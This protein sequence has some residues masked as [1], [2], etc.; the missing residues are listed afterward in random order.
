MDPVRRVAVAGGRRLGREGI[1]ALLA[2]VPTIELVA[3]CADRLTTEAAIERDGA[4]VVVTHV[5]LEGPGGGADL[6]VR[7]RDTH[8]GIGVVLLLGD[9][10]GDAEEVVEVLE[11]GTAQRALLLMDHPRVARDLVAAIEEVAEGGSVVHPGVV[12]RMLEAQRKPRCP[13]A[14]LTPRERQVL[15]VIATGAS[16]RVVAELLRL[17]DRALEKH[18]NQLYT[19]LGLPNDG[20]VHRRVAAT[21]VVH[22]RLGVA[23]PIAV[24]G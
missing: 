11:G 5:W 7:L 2:A 20:R 13:M 6:A 4:D 10:E 1:A 21:L 9:S 17:S 3:S 22:G 15:E 23:A 8:P 18:I 14:D 12:D 24:E 16:N 19:K